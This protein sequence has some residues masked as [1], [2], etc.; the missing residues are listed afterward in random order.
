MP[1]ETRHY[2]E[3]IEPQEAAYYEVPEEIHVYSFSPEPSGTK[4]AKLT[5]VHLHFGKAPGPVF[6]VRFK[7]P[8]TLD[9][10]IDALTLHREAVFG[11]RG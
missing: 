8:D 2:E 11:K 9:E 10:I 5:Q 3:T 1:S 6:L 7:G 4:D